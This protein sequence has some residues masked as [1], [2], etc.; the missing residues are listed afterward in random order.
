[1]IAKR[2]QRIALSKRVAKE[3]K[4]KP[5]FAGAYIDEDGKQTLFNNFYVVRYNEAVEDCIKAETEDNHHFI[6]EMFHDGINKASDTKTVI[7]NCNKTLKKIKEKNFDKGRF[8]YIDTVN[9]YGKPSKVYFNIYYL[10]Q[11]LETLT[12]QIV[13]MAQHSTH[14][15]VMP[16]FIKADNGEAI[17]CPVK[18]SDERT[19]KT[20]IDIKEII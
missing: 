20:T 5:L 4:D 15:N 18:I 10:K 11:I 19:K 6:A 13:L 8:M 2:T 14:Q 1:M 9:Y 17:L 12:G 3:L 16:I 7:P